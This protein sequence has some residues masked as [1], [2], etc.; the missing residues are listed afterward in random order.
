MIFVSK[1]QTFLFFIIDNDKIGSKPDRSFGS[2]FYHPISTDQIFA[3]L[4]PLR[5]GSKPVIFT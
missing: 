5:E 1:K 2:P 3:E 4:E